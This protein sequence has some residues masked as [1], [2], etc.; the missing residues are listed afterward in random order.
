MGPPGPQDVVSTEQAEAAFAEF[1]ADEG[2]AL[3]YP[4]D[5][6]YARTHLMVRRLLARGLPPKKI[7]AFAASYRDLLWADTPYTP[8]G[9]VRWRYHVAPTLMVVGNGAQV[10]EMVL[11]PLL[12]D[13]LAT[14]DE[15]LASLHD[16]PKVVRTVPG[17][18]LPGRGGTG[19]SPGPDPPEGADNHA[20]EILEAYRR[21]S[22]GAHP[23]S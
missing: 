7:W 21:R 9:G 18:P 6:C 3:R 11:D 19:Y 5:G 22:P 4:A 8:S 14:V 17:E 1:A 13:R 15:W 2:L 20:V 10:E 23:R 12:F 16:T